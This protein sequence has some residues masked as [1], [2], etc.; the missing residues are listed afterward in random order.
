MYKTHQIFI[1]SIAIR[2]ELDFLCVPCACALIRPIVNNSIREITPAEAEQTSI[3]ACAIPALE[4]ISFHFFFFI[5]FP[6]TD[7]RGVSVFL[8]IY[9]EQVD[10]LLGLNKL[11]AARC[12]SKASRITGIMDLSGTTNSGQKD[13]DPGLT[14]V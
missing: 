6:P 7:R 13:D 8:E 2:S 12:D 11:N 1:I 10:L 4:N 5:Q 9:E 14:S 3:T